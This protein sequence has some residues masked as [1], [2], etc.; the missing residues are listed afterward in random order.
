M[1]LAAMSMT[2]RHKPRQWQRE[3]LNAWTSEFRGVV[4]VVTG[5]GKTFFAMQCML[6]VW[7]A[8][9]LTK[10]LVVVP[11]VALMD[12]WRVALRDELKLKDDDIDLIGGGV[13]RLANSRVTV[14]VLN[15]VRRIAHDL[16][17]Q[18]AWFLIV[19]ECHRAA[20]PTNRKILESELHRHIGSLSY[21]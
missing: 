5:A 3:A 4:S 16:T 18:G 15:S 8:S 10:V 1:D 17:E 19:D 2:T 20:S 7:H 14:G 12:Q 21:S 9:P 6:A 13:R 11:T